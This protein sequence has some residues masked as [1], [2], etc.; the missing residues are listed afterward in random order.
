V[1]TD[2]RLV[3]KN[4]SSG[5]PDPNQ[6]NP[7]SETSTGRWRPSGDDYKLIFPTGGE[8]MRLDAIVQG[9]RLTVTGFPFPLVFDR[10]V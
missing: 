1:G 2:E 5:T 6:P 10:E 9:E 3:A 8:E 7:P 4:F